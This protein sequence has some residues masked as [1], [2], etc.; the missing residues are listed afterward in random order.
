M[1]FPVSR[2]TTKEIPVNS[3]QE[4]YKINTQKGLRFVD[5]APSAICIG[6]THAQ[7]FTITGIARLSM[8]PNRRAGCAYHFLLSTIH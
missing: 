6:Y 1:K 5:Q 2:I 7:V 8:P 4:D 3:K